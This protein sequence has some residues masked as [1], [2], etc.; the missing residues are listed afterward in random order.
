MAFVTSLSGNFGLLPGISPQGPLMRIATLLVF[1][2]LAAAP[3]VLFPVRPLPAQPTPAAARNVVIFV[4]DGLRA[5]AVNDA[6][7]PNM[8]ALARQG[9]A[10]VNSHAMYPTLTMANASAIATGHYFGD[11][12]VFANT[13]NAGY[14]V[15]AAGGTPTPFIENDAVLGDLDRHFG[16][17]FLHE[18][19]I[20][21]LARDK[22]YSTAAIGKV[23]PT[24]LFDHTE[25]TGSQTIVIDDVTGTERG[26]P[27]SAEIAERIKA[28]GFAPA[29]PPR[30]ANAAAG[31]ATMPG[32]HSANT[33]Q[34]DYLTAVATRAVL[35]LFAA[36]RKPFLLVFWSRDPDGTQHNQGDSFLT[37]AP[38]INGATSLAAIR[39]ADDDLGRIRAALSELGLAQDTD[40][41]VTADHGFSTI[42][43]ESAT[44]AA[45]KA[46][47]ADVPAGL[48]PPGFLAIDLAAALGLPLIDY[49]AG[50]ATVGEAMHPRFGNGL[51]GD[52]DHPK[53]MVVANGGSDLIYLPDGD[54]E[55]AGRIVAALTA[56]DYVSGLFVDGRLG[57]FPGALSLADIGLE[58]AALTPAPAIVVNFRSFDTVCGEP[59]RC[60]VEIADAGLQQGQ[61]MH[62]SFSRADTWNFMALAG[63]DF[64]SGFVDPAPASNA[65]IAR[66]VGA[67]MG[68]EFMDRGTLTGRVLAEAMPG[69]TIPDAIGWS[70]ASA[71]AADGA[72][73]VL[74]LQAVG[75]VRYFDAAGFIGRTLGLSQGTATP[76][77]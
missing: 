62:G 19:T 33:A 24:L 47:Y 40:I 31:N 35:P 32:T 3:A 11:T 74:D 60:P 22:G 77:R 25:R 6:T 48:L 36:R 59:V 51:L 1:G 73:T 41:V 17:D 38:G 7:A 27:L 8:A 54:K 55:L 26:I 21:K 16:G 49:D 4:A 20:L 71:P 64:K 52:K 67:I 53:A 76:A 12:G 42:A 39:N 61:G 65:D 14:P 68:L 37:L 69:G 75:A 72:R 10:L 70:V 43:K 57:R 29:P 5:R 13:L 46:R 34:Q 45:A 50:Y 18:D 15:A 58:G 2:F 66:T 28:A 9:V 44:S 63:P 23:G 56:Q 30:G